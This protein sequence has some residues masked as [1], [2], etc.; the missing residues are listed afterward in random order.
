MVRRE[1]TE[2]NDDPWLD[3]KDLDSARDT[4]DGY[5]LDGYTLG[6]RNDR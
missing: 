6:S 5:T 4:L 2:R 1:T 3:S